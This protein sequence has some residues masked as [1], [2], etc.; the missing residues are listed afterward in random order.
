MTANTESPA[1]GPADSSALIGPR[2]V[3]VDSHGDLFIADNGGAQAGAVEEVTAVGN[4]SVLAIGGYKTSRVENPSGVAVDT[5]G[6]LFIA[7]SDSNE[8][9]EVDP[10]RQ[11]SVVVGHGWTGPPVPGP[12]SGSPFG[13]PLAVAVDAHGDLFI[14]DTYNDD[15]EKVAW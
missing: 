2:G 7:D 12:A 5:H 10:A 15:V 14:A 11:W 8:V 6:N 4:L 1:Q 9:E 13:T 3:A